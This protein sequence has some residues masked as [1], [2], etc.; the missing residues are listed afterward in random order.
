ML[1]F[2]CGN[3]LH[4]EL[5]HLKY[6]PSFGWV[7]K[8]V[9]HFYRP[10]IECTSNWDEIRTVMDSIRILSENYRGQAF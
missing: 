8:D 1:A 9:E 4:P 6:H 7:R 10:Y 3:K 2:M 5:T